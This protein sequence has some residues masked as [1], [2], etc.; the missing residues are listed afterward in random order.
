MWIRRIPPRVLYSAFTPETRPPIRG[1]ENPGIKVP[2]ACGH[3]PK[4]KTAPRE[5]PGK[6]SGSP[7]YRRCYAIAPAWG[8]FD[9]IDGADQVGLGKWG[10]GRGGQSPQPTPETS[11]GASA[12]DWDLTAH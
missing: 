9:L 1:S 7:G 4:R 5:T 11:N 8:L 10:S 12:V 2:V 3:S 6:P